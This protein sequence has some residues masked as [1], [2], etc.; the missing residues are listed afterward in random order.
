MKKTHIQNFRE[1]R[2]SKIQ[3]SRSIDADSMRAWMLLEN[4]HWG[5]F[6]QNRNI[7]SLGELFML[8]KKSNLLDTLI[9]NESSINESVQMIYEDEELLEAF[10]MQIV[11][12][13]LSEGVGSFFNKVARSVFGDDLVNKVEKAWGKLGD[14][15]TDIGKKVLDKGK[16]VWDKSVDSLKSLVKNIASV[17]KS[18][19]E[20]I[21]NMLNILWS[22]LTSTA[23]KV[24]KTL[25]GKSADKM[26]EVGNV[27]QG[28]TSEAKDS[29]DLSELKEAAKKSSFKKEATDLGTDLTEVRKKYFGG[30]QGPGSSE[31]IKKIEDSGSELVDAEKS[32]DAELKDSFNVQLSMDTVILESLK[33]LCTVASFEEIE[34]LKNYESHDFI[35]EAK[36]LNE[37]DDHHEKS[38]VVAWLSEIVKWVLS[39]MG[40]LIE[41]LTGSLTRLACS[42][43]SA[44][45]RGWEKRTKFVIFPTLT[46]FIAGLAYKISGIAH[47]FSES[48]VFEKEGTEADL[49]EAVGSDTMDKLE[50]LTIGGLVGV[51]AY[52]F[53]G[54]M[55]TLAFV[56]KCVMTALLTAMT[57]GF[58]Q[59]AFPKTFG[60][61]PD[62][63]TKFYHAMH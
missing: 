18:I 21:K 6:I 33:G 23:G 49:E 60:W 58:L 41:L 59:E 8:G 27:L 46:A 52:I 38:A 30:D 25:L 17:A 32:A 2:N 26:K 62:F 47:H 10:K 39:P 4:Y 11:Y 45:A 16:E 37:G 63:F 9:V 36:K 54:A 50:K 44:I 5:P 28:A 3:E 14:K 35:S 20:S 51:C 56:F 34:K 53:L 55:P 13:F 31:T 15:I 40:N 12:D 19:G 22:G 1:W 29:G 43:P 57:V 61:V 42:V 7:P 48:E 24:G